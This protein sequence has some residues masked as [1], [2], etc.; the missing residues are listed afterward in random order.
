MLELRLVSPLTKVFADSEPSNA[1]I[2]KN[3]SALQGEKYT[4]QLAYCCSEYVIG[5][6]KLEIAD[7]P[8]KQHVRMYRVVNVVTARMGDV[9]KRTPEEKARFERITPGLFPD[10]LKNDVKEMLYADPCVWYAVWVEVDIPAGFAAGVYPLSFTLWES[11]EVKQTVSIDLEVIAAELPPQTLIHTEWFYCDCICHAYHIKPWTEK[12]WKIVEV[13]FRNFVAHGINML[14]TPIVTP[15]L[16]TEIGGERLT[17]Q[18]V[19]VKVTNGQYSFD[20]SLLKRWIRLALKCG[21]KY[22]EMSHLFTQGGAK[23][24]PKVTAEVDG[25]KE[26]RIFGWETAATSAEYTAFLDAMLPELVSFLK[27]QGIA[28]NCYFHISDEPNGEQVEQYKAVSRIV[29]KHLDGFRVLDAASHTQYFTD[30]LIKLPVPC[31]FALNDFLPLDIPERWTYYCGGPDLPYSNRLHCMPA[32]AN[33]IMGTLLYIYDVDGF[34]HWGYNF[35]NSGRSRRACDPL[36][37]EPDH[38]YHSG[39]QCLVYPGPEGPLDTMRSEVFYAGLQDLRALRLLES[40]AGRDVVLELIRKTAG[41]EVKIDNF[42]LVPSFLHD[43]RNAV[44]AGIAE[45]VKKPRTA[46]NRKTKKAGAK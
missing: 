34:L 2:L 44:N 20:F 45:R 30:G 13:Y 18:L 1:L 22:F 33:R 35:W 4:F 32:S 43:L 21:V 19:K 10:L 8:L 40:L 41:Q 29:C 12:F 15:A 31:E 46:Q 11:D 28:E 25:K 7:S 37:V 17:T 16:D 6:M 24:A 39:D 14:Y 23:S 9:V 5:P 42:P 38:D 3:G 36:S 26:Q 27:K